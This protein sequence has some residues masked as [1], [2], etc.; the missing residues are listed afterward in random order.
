MTVVT[1]GIDIGTSS[2]KALAVDDD[3]S[4]VARARVVHS[5]S[6]PT[7]G[8]FEHDVNR[9][10]RRNVRAAFRRVADGHEVAAVNVAAFVPSL[11]AV[12]RRGRALSPGL[13][14]GDE[15]GGAATGRSPSESGEVLNMLRWCAQQRP[16]AAGFWPAQA[17]ANHALC[18]VGAIDSVVAITTHPLHDYTDWDAEVARGAGV[19]VEQL[20]RVVPGSAAIGEIT[21][22][23]H[24]RG[25]VGPGTIDA[26]AE[27][28]VA[29][30]DHDG[31]VLVIMG[32]TLITWGVVPAV[33]GG[34]RSVD[35]APHRARPDAHRRAI[36]RRR[37][38]PRLG[39]PS[40]RQGRPGLRPAAHPGVVAL[41]PR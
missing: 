36:Q 6:S 13:L 21:V 23:G 22:D 9:A 19:S 35:R 5:V 40:A 7:A 25:L 24:R 31:D 18:G 33:A 10:W 14:Y 20:P 34:A 15:R 28:M 4:V 37:P 1:V 2:V 29:G 12:D 41:C 17:V 32:T 39:H 11:C 30:A 8:R 38:L 3:G 26:L 27:Q 16:D